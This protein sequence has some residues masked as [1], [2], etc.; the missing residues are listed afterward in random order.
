MIGWVGVVR[1]LEDS[2]GVLGWVPYIGFGISVGFLTAKPLAIRAQCTT[3][4]C[5]QRLTLLGLQN[6][7]L[8]ETTS[9]SLSHMLVNGKVK[10]QDLL[11]SIFLLW[12]GTRNMTQTRVLCTSVSTSNREWRVKF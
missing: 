6:K 4:V 2:L 10:R 9:D 12:I 1:K 11:N 3:T 7:Y 8:L 5:I